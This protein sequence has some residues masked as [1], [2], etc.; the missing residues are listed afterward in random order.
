MNDKKTIND[1]DLCC[2]TPNHDVASKLFNY[3][4][5]RTIH[6]LSYLLEVYEA[7]F[8]IELKEIKANVQQCSKPNPQLFLFH[9]ALKSAIESQDPDYATAIIDHFK[10]YS[11]EDF[12]VKS[13]GKISYVNLDDQDWTIECAKISVDNN[14]YINDW[15]HNK[16]EKNFLNEIAGVTEDVFLIMKKLHPDLYR[17]ILVHVN[18]IILSC[19]G[20]LIGPLGYPLFGG[21]SVSY[22]GA[23][24]M[25]IPSDYVF[26][27]S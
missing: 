6:S 21:T 12:S 1:A 26:L 9:H 20:K 2:V 23:L 5:K 3:I 11:S 22:H 10:T 18:T 24:F 16:T 15:S 17:E 8:N 27:K 14:E 13:S 7:H 19:D 4:S 25:Q